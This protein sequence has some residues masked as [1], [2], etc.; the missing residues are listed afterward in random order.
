MAM[1]R[2]NRTLTTGSLGPEVH[3]LCILGLRSSREQKFT[4]GGE[5][6]VRG[7]CADK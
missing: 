3:Y 2:E 5:V 4:Q 1:E 6:F 7:D